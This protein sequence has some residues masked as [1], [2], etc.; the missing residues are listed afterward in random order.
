MS[1]GGLE[2]FGVAY[3][4][5]LDAA[6]LPFAAMAPMRA[7]VGLLSLRTFS[8]WQLDLNGLN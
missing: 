7:D 8:M 5:G 1:K 3:L 2:V 6:R 4:L